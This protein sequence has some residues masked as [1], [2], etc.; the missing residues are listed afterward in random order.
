MAEI[1]AI[2]AFLNTETD[3]DSDR[4]ILRNPTDISKTETVIDFVHTRFAVAVFVDETAQ[5]IL[6]ILGPL[7]P[8]YKTFIDYA[9]KLQDRD[10]PEHAMFFDVRSQHDSWALFSHYANFELDSHTKRSKTPTS[11][12]PSPTQSSTVLMSY[13]IWNWNGVWEDRK[14][15]LISIILEHSPDIIGF[16]E[17]RQ[18]LDSGAKNQLAQ[19]FADKR[20]K[21]VYKSMIYQPNM[22][23]SHD[24]EGIGVLSKTSILQKDSQKLSFVP[25]TPDSNRRGILHTLVKLPGR[26]YLDFFVTHWSYA[27]GKGQAKNSDET[28]AFMDQ[29]YKPKMGDKFVPQVIVG[30]FN[31]YPEDTSPYDSLAARGK[32]RDVWSI[33]HPDEP[34]FTFSNLASSDLHDRADRILARGMHLQETELVR[35][36]WRENFNN[37]PPSDHLGLVMFANVDYSLNCTAHK[38]PHKYQTLSCSHIVEPK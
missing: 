38:K 18:N 23:Y 15:Q 14:E 27:K 8:R 33:A 13:N 9:I 29:F 34:G 36:G 28:L 6:V 1:N 20:I 4:M 22:V 17:I 3:V 25:H 10:T 24:E 32:M 11:T 5:E 7:T 30:D 37:I 31:I 19:I 16:Q 21:K 2:L 12:Q 26:G 35:V